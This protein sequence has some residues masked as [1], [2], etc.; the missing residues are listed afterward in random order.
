MSQVVVVPLAAEALELGNWVIVLSPGSDFWVQPSPELFREL[1]LEVRVI[2]EMIPIPATG[3]HGP[4][5]TPPADE[6]AW[7]AAWLYDSGPPL[8]IP[9]EPEPDPLLENGPM[10]AA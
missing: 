7:A 3:V 1:V 9:P 8:P 2:G 6:L 5:A 10:P 4:P